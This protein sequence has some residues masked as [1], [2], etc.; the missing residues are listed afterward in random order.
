MNKNTYRNRITGE[1]TSDSYT[2]MGWMEN[3]E[4]FDLIDSDGN[5]VMGFAPQEVGQ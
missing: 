5:A 3:G 4:K 1:V 2:L